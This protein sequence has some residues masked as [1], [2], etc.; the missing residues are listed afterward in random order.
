MKRIMK[1]TCYVVLVGM[2][3][4]LV[5]SLAVLIGAQ[6]SP[7]LGQG[8]ISVGDLEI[9]IGGLFNQS[10]GIVLLAW[11]L[12]AAAF[13]A[14]GL[15]VVFALFITAAALA[16]TALALVAMMF[17]VLSPFILFGLLVWFLVRRSR[18]A[19]PSAPTA[20]SAAA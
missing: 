17:V 3:L 6:F 8:V 11:L 4:A 9:E 10:L 1:F 19:P 18:S 5:A 12:M 2:A 15:A 20:P 13:A 16:F 7:E 14:A